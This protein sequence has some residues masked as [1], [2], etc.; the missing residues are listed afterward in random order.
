MMSWMK[1]R[2]QKQQRRKSIE[3]ETRNLKHKVILT[4]SD[5]EMLHEKLRV[6]DR[7]ER[8]RL[9]PDIQTYDDSD[10]PTVRW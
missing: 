2:R 3:K 5:P 6:L 4:E 1:N 9:G 7:E 8:F 10:E